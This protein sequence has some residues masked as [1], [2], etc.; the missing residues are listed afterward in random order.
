MESRN[1]IVAENSGL[2]R[3][4]TLG[5]SRVSLTAKTLHIEGLMGGGPAKIPVGAIDSITVQPSWFWHR[6]TIRL[7]D[8]TERSV[9]GLDE[10]EAVQV[11]DAVIEGAVR[12]A[13]ALSPHLKRLDER[14]R[15]YLAGDR[16][17]RNGDSRKLHEALAPVLRECKG[18]TRE[19]LDQ[20]AAEV[21]GRLAPLESIEGF[22]S[23]RQRANDLFISRTIP[24]VQESDELRQ[25]GELAPGCPRCRRGRLRSSQSPMYLICSDSNCDNRAPRCPNCDVGYALVGGRVAS[26]TNQDCRRPLSVCPRCGL[27]VL[28][29]IDSR[30]GPFWCCTEYGSKQSCRYKKDIESSAIRR[31]E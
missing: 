23:A 9:G 17:A 2:H 27:G 6:L 28:R 26:C 24:T 18:L 11:R 8:G 29:V 25:I 22:E 1:R 19:R 13:K 5:P 4:F 21:V 31:R 12:V 10:R 7:S 15:Q 20:E 14:L 30:F 16:Y 3:L